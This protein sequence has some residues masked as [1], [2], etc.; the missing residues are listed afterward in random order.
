MKLFLVFYLFSGRSKGVNWSDDETGA[1]VEIWQEPNVA[2][3][4]AL[5]STKSKNHVYQDIADRLNS[6]FQRGEFRDAIQ[7]IC[8]TE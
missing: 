3:A 7:V 2:N 4:I 1:L 6:V 8:T 5:Q